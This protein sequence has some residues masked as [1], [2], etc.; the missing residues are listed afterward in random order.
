MSNKRFDEKLKK[1]VVQLHLQGKAA[2]KLGKEYNVSPTSIYSW[3]KLYAG[4]SKISAK[5]FTEVQ[6]ENARLKQEV[7]ILKQAMTIMNSK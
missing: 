7:K 5:A 4:Q 1:E 2:T 3:T 6:K